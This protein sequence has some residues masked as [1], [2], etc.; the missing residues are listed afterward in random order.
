MSARLKVPQEEGWDCQCS[1]EQVM[2]GSLLS[3][4]SHEVKQTAPGREKD[5]S[6]L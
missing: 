2:W 6:S 3:L 4:A 1:G 5:Y